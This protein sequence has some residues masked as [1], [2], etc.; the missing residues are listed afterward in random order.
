VRPGRPHNHPACHMLRLAKQFLQPSRLR[1]R[2]V[3][4][5]PVTQNN[6]A[7]VVGCESPALFTV[8]TDAR[9][10]CAWATLQ[11]LLAWLV[12][13]TT[14]TSLHRAATR[15]VAPAE[16]QLWQLARTFQHCRYLKT[17]S[18]SPLQVKPHCKSNLTQPGWQARVIPCICVTQP[19]TFPTNVKH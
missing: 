9:R 4:P 13:S 10:S 7:H 19:L 3:G 2:W 8:I 16:V 1:L 14:T 11:V 6:M 17:E 12:A 5:I 15:L 18:T